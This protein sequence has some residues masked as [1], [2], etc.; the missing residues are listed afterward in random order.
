MGA[1]AFILGVLALAG[2][3]GLLVLFFHF[4]RFLLWPFGIILAIGVAT[5]IGYV[6]MGK[7][8]TLEVGIL[9][10][11]GFLGCLLCTLDED[12]YW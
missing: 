3:I 1:E 6:I 4:G 9:V 5:G 10:G 7:S 11:I 2:L 12:L 8:P